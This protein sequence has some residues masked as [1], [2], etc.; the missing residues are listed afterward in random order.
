[1]P[2]CTRP[3]SARK[4]PSDLP[5]VVLNRLWQT[6]ACARRLADWNRVRRFSRVVFLVL[7]LSAMVGSS[8]A[9]ALGNGPATANATA[10]L[11]ARADA[12]SALVREHVAWALFRLSL[13]VQSETNSDSMGENVLD[14]KGPRQHD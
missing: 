13:K 9:V 14:I 3:G 5:F 12:A 7:A 10:A 11:Q 1:M 6:L 8:A 4:T 2:A